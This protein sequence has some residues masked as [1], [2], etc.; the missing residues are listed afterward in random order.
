MLNVGPTADGDIPEPLAARLRDIGKW[1]EKNGEAIYG[2]HALG[3]LELPAG[4]CTV[5][6]SRL[7]VHL[8]TRPGDKLSLA[9]IANDMVRA[10]LLETGEVLAV[11]AAAKTISLPDRLP[12]PVVTTIAVELAGPPRVGESG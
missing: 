7:Y 5:K 1:L 11:D 3:A 4:K 10:W 8:E 2:T 6:G 12:D 9:G